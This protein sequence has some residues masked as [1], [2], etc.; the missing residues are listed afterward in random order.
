MF[1]W[2]SAKTPCLIF[3]SV[4]NRLS[5]LHLTTP[6]ASECW[7]VRHDL[8]IHAKLELGSKA[9]SSRG[10]FLTYSNKSVREVF[11]QGICRLHPPGICL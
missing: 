9:S 7:V 5:V 4:L 2:P 3:S 8:Q 1:L 10:Q 11:Q 6:D